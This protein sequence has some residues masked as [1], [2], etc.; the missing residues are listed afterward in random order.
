[1]DSSVDR[2]TCRICGSRDITR[3]FPLAEF[4]VLLCREC[5]V[6]FLSHIPNEA[7]LPTL[8]GA[9]YYQTRAQYYFGNV[10]WNPQQGLSDQNIQK[11]QR[12]L[13]RLRKL[14]PVGGRLLDVGCG[15]GI[16]LEMARRDGW[17]TQ[18]IDASP[19]AVAQA[20]EHFGLAVQNSLNVGEANLT[21]GSFD[22]I[23]L[24]D[25]L[26]HFPDPLGQL[27]GISRLLKKDGVL[28]L[29]TPN[30]DALMRRI[31]EFLF[32]ATGGR[33]SYPVGKLHH[34]FHLYYF[35][36]KALRRLL[37]QT[38]F[39]VVALEFEQIP[40]VKARGN[41]AEKLLVKLFKCLEQCCGQPFEMVALAHRTP[42]T[43]A[44]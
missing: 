13:Q 28:L 10:I 30:A 41:T 7:E 33:F 9:E 31:A 18:G 44:E 22:V 4:D 5:T 43:E 3:R 27:R 23:T 19:Y 11:F 2:P 29:N 35:T 42:G 39:G 36:Q 21:L 24:W 20:R 8:Y 17:E 15:V 16:F 12:A 38:G 6:S 34:R 26:E 37:E 25:S 40:L 32:V 1:M 14:K